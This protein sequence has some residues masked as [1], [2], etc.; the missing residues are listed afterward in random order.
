MRIGLATTSISTESGV[1]TYQAMLA[2]Q[3]RTLGHNVVQW[4]II[5]DPSEQLWVVPQ[6]SQL[7][8]EGRHRMEIG[9]DLHPWGLELWN[10]IDVLH[11][12]DAGRIDEKYIAAL[13]KKM[14]PL[15]VS[16]HD[17]YE[18]QTL[19]QGLLF[20]MDRAD[21][22]LFIGE[23]FMEATR[24]AE[25]MAAEAFER[26]AR[27]TLQPY[28]RVAG[29]AEWEK[30]RRVINTS[31]W[32]WNKNISLIVDA[33]DRLRDERPIEFWT[34]NRNPDVECYAEEQA[35][36]DH[37]SSHDTP[38]QW[39]R[40]A[41]LIY[42]DAAVLVDCVFFD[43]TD[44]GR[45]E[46]PILEAWDFGV[47]P[48]VLEGFIGNPLT[49]ELVDGYNVYGTAP[50]IEALV[51]TIKHALDNPLPQAFMD[52]SLKPHVMAG[53]LFA[54]AYLETLMGP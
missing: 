19:G 39:P 54:R 32:R 7:L 34:S 37:C 48:V 24:D 5:G 11:I 49:T 23:R 33:A 10:Q 45:T 36:W 27:L 3:L 1:N 53:E 28:V 31:P 38:W 20:L 17:P 44:T 30:H 25:W 26:K 15:V 51:R 46:Y 12:T 6:R 50:G 21:K 16:I 8:Q 42:G 22:I 18:F 35:G 52:E 13:D 29:G 47:T 9:K 43:V 14:G 41:E 2:R 40:D 4:R